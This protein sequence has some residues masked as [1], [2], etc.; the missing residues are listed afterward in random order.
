MIAD[1]NFYDTFG[2]GRR[3]KLHLWSNTGKIASVKCRRYP[4]LHILFTLVF[5][6]ELE[7]WLYFGI[8]SIYLEILKIKIDNWLWSKLTCHIL[9][10]QVRLSPRSLSSHDFI[11]NQA[12]WVYIAFLW[13]QITMYSIFWK[14]NGFY[15]SRYGQRSKTWG[16]SRW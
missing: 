11:Q 16:W 7:V 3:W 6:T 15:S 10:S 8:K 14:I 13:A 9:K 12:K 4:T 2:Y 5:S 1:Q